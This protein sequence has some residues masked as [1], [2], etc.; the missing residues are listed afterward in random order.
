MVDNNSS[1]DSVEVIKK[2]KS[3]R[4][5]VI[6]NKKNVGFAAGCNIGAKHA[7]GDALLF[8]NSDTQLQ[9]DDTIADLTALLNKENVAVVG[10][11][12]LNTDNSF[13]RS[14]GSFYSLPH[15]AKMLFFGEKS[16]L[17]GQQFSKSQDVDW[18]SGGFMLV[19]REV[20]EKLKGFDEGYFMYVED[21]DLCYRVK[22]AGYRVVVNPQVR[23]LHVGQGSSNRTFA[24]TS[25]YK[26]LSRFYK[27][28]Y[29]SV[30]YKGLQVLLHAK[31]Y[32]VMLFGTIKKDRDLV[33]RY[34]QALSSL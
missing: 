3:P 26:G 18:V 34:K 13:Q 22:K 20:F 15:V 4:I 1:D 21:V 16:E 19:T 33:A 29:S 10:G 23:V 28:H 25:I 14:F 7:T 5:T 11:L 32:M 27:Q 31:A 9:D 12:L 17:S 24:V 2:L 30:E 6:E 8:L